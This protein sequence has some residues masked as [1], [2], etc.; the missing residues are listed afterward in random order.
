MPLQNL[1]EQYY[2]GSGRN[3]EDDV[4]YH[5]LDE[6]G[7]VFVSPTHVLLAR[8]VCLD[9][10]S[11][12]ITN[13]AHHFPLSQCN[14]W[15]IHLLIGTPGTLVPQLESLAGRLPF[16]VFQRGDFRHQHQLRVYPQERFLKLTHKLKH[17]P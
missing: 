5:L 1:I 2:R 11:A 10:T 16:L 13:P 7:V 15:H 6:S 4:M 8:A 12:R 9:S 3:F 14:A 17:T